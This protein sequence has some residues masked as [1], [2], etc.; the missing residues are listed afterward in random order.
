MSQE[1]DRSSKSSSQSCDAS[2]MNPSAMAT[3]SQGQQAPAFD[4]DTVLSN[5][6][7]NVRL[8][9]V[10]GNNGSLLS[11][12][13]GFTEL[14]KLQRQEKKSLMF[15]STK[16]ESLAEVKEVAELESDD[17]LMNKCEFIEKTANCSTAAFKAIMQA[18]TSAQQTNEPAPDADVITI[19]TGMCHYY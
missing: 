15:H 13:K 16:C 10:F 9:I 2:L 14:R 6:N 4:L 3:Q 5:I 1:A 19:C 7:S 11:M 17:Q 12:I 8:H 18:L